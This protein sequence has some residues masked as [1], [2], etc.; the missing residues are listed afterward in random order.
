V[1]LLGIV[2]GAIGLLV[3]RVRV[4]ASVG[5]V[6]IAVGLIFWFAGSYAYY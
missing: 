5:S 6:L 2:L 3:P 1:I 4:L